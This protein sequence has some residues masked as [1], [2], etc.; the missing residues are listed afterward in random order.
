MFAR[1]IFILLALLAALEQPASIQ[2]RRS[3]S[4]LIAY[5][6]LALVITQIERL[7]HRRSWHLPL[8]CDLLALGYFMFI[9]P[10]TVPVWFPYI[11]ICY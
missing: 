2:E 3:V 10:V 4:F 1:P 7:L 11:F 5:L 6:I 9:S 8:A